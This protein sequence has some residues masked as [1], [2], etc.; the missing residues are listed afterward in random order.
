MARPWRDPRTGIF[1]LRKKVHE[2]LRPFMGCGMYKRSL[3]TTDPNEALR[4]FP[5]ALAEANAAFELA[6]KAKEGCAQLNARDA[7]Q[8][9]ARW[10]AD[11]RKRLE[12]SGEWQRW[13]VIGRGA[14]GDEADSLSMHMDDDK[15][16]QQLLEN[17]VLPAVADMLKTQGQ[18]MPAANP[19]MSSID[20]LT[21]T[22]FKRALLAL[23]GDNQLTPITVR[24]SSTVL[25]LYVLVMIA[26]EVMM[27]S[28]GCL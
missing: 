21:G 16:R 15:Q 28:F 1:Y 14:D 18:A 23:E 24:D 5:D 20:R 25:S 8:L 7:Q 4:R 19:P 2:S 11:E 6:R 13:L 12:Q 17:L 27:F 26:V 3:R 22:A 10:F 9:A